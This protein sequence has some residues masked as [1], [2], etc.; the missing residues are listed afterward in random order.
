MVFE[1]RGEIKNGV[2]EARDWSGATEAYYLSEKDGITT[3]QVEMEAVDGG[4]SDYFSNTF[5][6][7]LALAKQLAEQ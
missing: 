3:L 2:Q 6:K 7:A 1:H 5:P 4:M